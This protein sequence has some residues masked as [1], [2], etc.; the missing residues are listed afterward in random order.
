MADSKLIPNYNFETFIVGDSNEAAHSMAHI[1]ALNQEKPRFNPLIVCGGIGTGKTHLLHAIGNSVQSRFPHV[2]FRTS[3]SFVVGAVYAYRTKSMQNFQ[4]RIRNIDVLLLDDIQCLS[5]KKQT[6][7]AFLSALDTMCELSKQVVISSN[8]PPKDLEGME[9]SLVHRLET[10]TL[11]H[12]DRA[13]H[14][15]KIALINKKSHEQELDLP[16]NVVS[17]IADTTSTARDIE[18]ALDRLRAARDLQNVLLNLET[19]QL[20]LNG[21]IP[22]LKVDLTAI[23]QTVAKHF[24]L[25]LR[26]LEA[27]SNS[28][29]I[30]L[31]RQIVMYLAKT[32]TDLSLLQIALHFGKHHTT[33]LHAVKKIGENRKR[34]PLLDELLVSLEKDLP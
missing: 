24:S 10:S 18:G 8:R 9:K 14:L 11:I 1:V 3:E 28:A 20:V 30:V 19:T 5:R 31:P 15:L 23:Q 29:S 16:E 17:Y 22:V 4:A 21:P 33:V 13:D 25:R 2:Y 6:Q 12:I 32:L 26:D 7:F 27:R 34:D